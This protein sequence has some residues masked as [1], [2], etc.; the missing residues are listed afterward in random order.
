MIYKPRIIQEHMEDIERGHDKCAL[1][2]PPG[3]GKTSATINVLCE[4]KLFYRGKTLIVAPLPVAANTWPSEIEKFDNFRNDL[5]YT[6]ITGNSSPKD[7]EKLLREDVDAYICNYE[8]LPWLESKLKSKEFRR[9]RFTNCVI[10]EST[11]IKNYRLRKGS[12]RARSLVKISATCKCIFELTGTPGD[13]GLEDLWGQIYVLDH[14][15]RLGSA[16][17]YFRPKYF[18]NVSEG[19]YPLWEPRP[20]AKQEIF[21]KLRDI[22]FSIDVK[23]YYPVDEFIEFTIPVQLPGKIMDQYNELKKKFVLKLSEEDIVTAGSAG[24]A[25][26]KLLQII[27]GAI[28]KEGS[29][30]EYYVLHDCKLDALDR[31]IAELQENVFIVYQFRHTCDRLLQRYK[32][33][34]HFSGEPNILKKWN[35]GKISIIISHPESIQFGINMQYGGRSIIFIDNWYSATQVEQISAR[36]GPYR[37]AQ[38]GFDRECYRYRIVAQNTVETQV[39]KSMLK[40][41]SLNE[42]ILNEFIYQ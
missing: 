9:L 25:K 4:R 13:N 30:T 39:V 21:D 26:M 28:Y 8:M 18:E 37:Q 33:A 31:I 12:K 32:G 10:D 19:D 22:A 34:V 1:W 6:V 36:L 20:G 23:K 2:S 11:C 27:S 16:L 3:S 29:R 17:K 14:G 40:K 38:A 7:R 24:I 42:E 35:D 15:L 5:S 41:K